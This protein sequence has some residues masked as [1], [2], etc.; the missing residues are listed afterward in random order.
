MTAR[1]KHVLFISRQ[2]LV[3]TT[4]GSST[5]LIDLARAVRAAGMVPHLLQPAPTL[6][7]RW[8]MLTLR[9][10]M[11]VFETHVARGLL[12]VGNRLISLSPRLYSSVARAGVAALARRAGVQAAWARD[13]KAPYA[14]AIPWTAADHRFVAQ[15]ARGRCDV[16]IADYMFNAEAFA[17]LPAGTPT[18]IVMHD[19]FH[20][21]GSAATDSVAQVERAHE[22][23]MLARADAVIAI[24]ATEARF[25]AD[26]VPGTRAILAP[27]A[28][29]PVARPQP[30][31][32]DR[33]LFVGSDT[34]PN[35]DGLRWFFDA[36]WPSIRAAAPAT[37]LE[38][39]GSVARA[40]P[41]GAPEGVTLLG[42][43][44]SLVPLYAAAGVVISP[45]TFGSGLK[46][47]LI[48]ALA[49]GKA[50]VATPVTLQG[51]ERECAGAV[52]CTDDAAAFAAH[53]LALRD[54]ERRARQAAAALAVAVAH[55]SPAA[56]YRDVQQW[57]AASVSP[58]STPAPSAP[59]S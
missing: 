26:E 49:A 19:L 13:R 33:L 5:Y 56:C 29:T 20:A 55:F 36:V 8:P 43:V 31:T 59:A 53:V 57:L 34:A 6:M 21:R 38:V 27:M 32:A 16:A 24:Q 4:N 41:D 28:A 58:P 48:E 2:R 39:A 17:D 9:P 30:G 14:V 3:G 54:D 46:I 7:G 52:D 47:K 12:R 35:V 51:V 37:R 40:F 11:A 45:L 15:H 22:V 50:I 23:A 42:L 44:D 18:A 25:V 1:G 10:E